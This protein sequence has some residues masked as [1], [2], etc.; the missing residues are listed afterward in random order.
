MKKSINFYQRN[1]EKF[2]IDYPQEKYPG[3]LYKYRCASCGV[4]TL[5]IKGKLENH[6]KD[7]SYRIKI[8]NLA[9]RNKTKTS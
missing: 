6:L 1:T 5:K 7:C 2:F 4:N 3:E 9:V 8:E